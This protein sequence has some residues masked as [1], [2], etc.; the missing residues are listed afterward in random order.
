M[1]LDAVNFHPLG[2]VKSVDLMQFYNLLTGVMQDQ[3]ITCAMRS[4]S[5]ATRARPLCPSRSTGRRPEH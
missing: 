4:A 3:P 1:P 2:P 5:V